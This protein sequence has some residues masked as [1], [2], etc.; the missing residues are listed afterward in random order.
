M[1]NEEILTTTIWPSSAQGEI[2]SDGTFNDSKAGK[3]IFYLSVH[4]QF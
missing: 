4:V 3:A 2:P 1:N